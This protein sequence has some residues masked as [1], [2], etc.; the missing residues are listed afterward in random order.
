[1]E[2]SETSR[3]NRPGHDEGTDTNDH[4]RGK[5]YA[6][7]DVS[8]QELADELDQKE[9]RRRRHYRSTTD[10]GS[11]QRCPECGSVQLRHK[12][13]G[14]RQPQT[15]GEYYCCGCYAHFDEPADA[16]VDDQ[17]PVTDGGARWPRR[18]IVDAV[19]GDAGVGDQAPGGGC[20]HSDDD[21]PCW[22]CLTDGEGGSG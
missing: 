11:M 6:S 20:R 15:R 5:R 16:D 17:E 22:D 2:T 19:R 8:L 12:T 13:G 14:A 4:Q 7:D 21:L 1:M 18:A 3:D 9:L 10:R